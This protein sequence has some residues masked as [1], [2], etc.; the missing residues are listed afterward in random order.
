MRVVG[1]R[2]LIV[3]ALA[4]RSVSPLSLP[5][6]VLAQAVGG[7]FIVPVDAPV[8]DPYRPPADP[9]GPGNRGIEYDTAAGQVVR[10]AGAGIVAFAGVIAGERYVSIDH[11]GGLRTT[12]SYLATIAVSVGA[13]IA[14]GDIVGTTGL[15]PFHFGA[16]R[17]GE[18]IDPATLFASPD[19]VEAPQRARL[20]P[21]R[22]PWT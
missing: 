7:G 5:I 11:P 2:A 8:R 10:A 12:Y 1:L 17:F 18:Y 9:Y 14:Q 6:D 13:P 15:R 21:I 3:V 16:R 22:A 19:P 20:V 4:F